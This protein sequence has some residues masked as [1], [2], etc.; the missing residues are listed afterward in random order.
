MPD[1]HR[2]PFIICRRSADYV[3]AASPRKNVFPLRTNLCYDGGSG[4]PYIVGGNP[5]ARR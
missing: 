5:A 1:L 4:R 3:L 2:F